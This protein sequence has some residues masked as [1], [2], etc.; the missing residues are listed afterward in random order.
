[1][2]PMRLA[3]MVM[4]ALVVVLSTILAVAGVM[5]VVYFLLLILADRI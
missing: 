3:G 4:G 5:W 2:T 1:M